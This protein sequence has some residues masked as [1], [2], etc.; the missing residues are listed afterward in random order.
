MIAEGR[1]TVDLGPGGAVKLESNRTASVAALLIG[2][3]PQEAL[4]MLPLVFSLCARAHVSAARMAMGRQWQPQDTQLVLAENAREHLL[5]I[6][7]GWKPEGRPVEMP[8]APVM[9]LVG[10]METRP[11]DEVANALHGYLTSHVF[12][13][14][15]QD[16]LAIDTLGNLGAWLQG[17]SSVPQQ[18]LANLTGEH[19]Q[20]LG[21]TDPNYLP[22]L[23]MTPLLDRLDCAQFTLTPDWQGSPCETGPLARQNRHP[24]IVDVL[25]VFGAGLL[26]RLLARLVELAQIPAQMR[27]QPQPA[28][29]QPGMGVVETARG[30]L[31][32]SCRLHDDRIAGYA[33]LAPTEWNFHPRGVAAQSLATLDA[34]DKATLARQARA[35]LQAIDPCVD[36]D[37][38]VG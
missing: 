13:T 19:W 11:A 10:D 28:G 20:A 14:D 4:E 3:T 34:P 26:A 9:Q 25:K 24:L 21:A 6:M 12:G 2:R 30:R 35:V 33:I 23:A 1:I 38:R 37:L 8:T 32:H 7:L 18:Y 27:A 5:R 17:A 15:P 16:F 31:I 36:F 22:E 29:G